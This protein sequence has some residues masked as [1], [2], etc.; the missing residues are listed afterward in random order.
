M[1]TTR[2]LEQL[3]A[4]YDAVGAGWLPILEEL[5]LQ[6]LAVDPRYGVAQVK[7]KF[8]GLRV[9][10]ATPEPDAASLAI[11]AAEERA[12][13]TCE[14]CGQPGAPREGSWIK[15]LC[16]EHAVNRRAFS[17]GKTPW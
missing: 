4:W 16:D 9:Y 12:L 13:R 7:E 14:N 15:T 10:L 11:D 2:T 8:G 5:H 6:L 3:P 1:T 17:G